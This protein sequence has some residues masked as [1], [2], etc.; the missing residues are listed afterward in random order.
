VV[1]RVVSQNMVEF[2]IVDFVG[3]L[4]LESASDKV[5]LIIGHLHLKVI[6]DRAESSLSNE[7]RSA[8]VLILEVRLQ[9]ESS[10]THIGSNSH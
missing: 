4:C 9:K 8:T 3:T 5:I 7:T 1:T 6:E 2:N 10:K